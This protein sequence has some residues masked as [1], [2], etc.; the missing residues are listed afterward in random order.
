[1]HV[2]GRRDAVAIV[3]NAQFP[4]NKGGLC[5][6]GWSAAG[7]LAHRDRLTAP[8]IRD[9]NGTLKPATWEAALDTIATRVRAIQAAHGADAV[10]VFGSGALTNEKAY[11]LGKFARVALATS[12]IDYNGRFCMSSGAAASVR[13]FG[14]DRGLPFP[15]EDISRAGAVLL[16]GGNPG[17]TMPP[18]MQYFAT[19]RANGGQ[20]I[21]ADPRAST[22]A[23]WATVHLKLR[24]GT[25]AALANAVLHTLMAEGLID[26]EYIAARTEGFSEVRELVRAYDPQRVEQITGVPAAALLRAARIL[27]TAASSMVLTGRVPEQ[28]SQGV[29]NA[30]AYINLALALGQVGRPSGGFGCLTGQGNGQGGREHGQKADQLPGYRRID[31]P[32]ARRHIASLWRIREEDLPGPGKSAS[33]AS[34]LGYRNA[35]SF[36]HIITI[37]DPIEFVHEHKN[38]IV[39]QREVGVDTD[40]WEVALRNSLRA[41]PDVILIG[42]IRERHTMDYAVAFAETGHLCL[43]TLHANSTNQ[44]LDRIINFFP[45]DRRAQLLMDLSLNIRAFVAQ[46]LIPRRDGKGRV[47]AVEVM[48][49][50]PLISD[51]VFKGDISGIKELMKKSRELGMQTF[52][53][54]LFGLY[55]SGLISYEDALRNADSLND[56][57]LEIKLHGKEAKGRNVFSGIG[58]LDIV[59]NTVTGRP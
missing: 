34:L 6:K 57:R 41:A 21:V 23:Q 26:E 33:M 43:A 31:D 13:A 28:Q 40:N 52:D 17:E 47:P 5:V 32:D 30:L 8:L 51:L 25:D 14:L 45:E 48:L 27:G 58:N 9:A 1:M 24:P 22:T 16:A 19:Q 36:G 20:L 59:P 4:V 12:N 18:L 49:N 7:T 38:C 11:L 42:E 29:N 46:R 2:S 50:S 55:E 53:Q 35:N 54:S 3:G 10:G 44:A 56:L 37:E 39:T 15:L